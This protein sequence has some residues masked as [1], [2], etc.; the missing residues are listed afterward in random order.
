MKSYFLKCNTDTE[1]INLR[2]SKAS[3]SKK[4]LLSNVP[5][6]RVKNQDPMKIRKQK[7]Y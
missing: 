1:N 4:M 3:N 2:V 6:F 7:N 5:N